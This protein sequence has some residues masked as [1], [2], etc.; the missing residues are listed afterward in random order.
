MRKKDLYGMSSFQVM[1]SIRRGVFYTFLTLFMLEVL[2]RTFTEAM[3]VMALPMLAN[4]ITQPTIW[5]PL[6]DKIGKR[7]IFIALGEGIAGVAYILI[8]PPV[9]EVLVGTSIYFAKMAY[10]YT[11]V[12]GLTILES[13]WSMSNVGW[14]ALIADLTLP[15]ERG[16]VMGKLN[17]IGAVGRIAGVFIGGIL[18]DYPVKGGG[19]SYLFF[20]SS[21]IMFSSALLVIFVVDERKITFSNVEYGTEANTTTDDALIDR[22][23][24]YSFLLALSVLLIGLANINRILN[25]YLRLALLASS[26]DMSII[27]NVSSITQLI[28]NPLVGKLSD[29]KGRKTILQIGFIVGT[30]LPLLYIL[31]NTILLLIPVSIL[32]GFVRAIIMTVSYAY[33]AEVIPESLRGRYFGQYNMMRTLSFGVFPILTAGIFTDLLTSIFISAGL[34]S[35]EAQ[36][37]SMI[38]VFYESSVLGLIGLLLFQV[39]KSIKK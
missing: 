13:I 17:S 33:V 11:L 16:N 27:S 7:K 28:A 22:R 30:L 14:S 25:Y 10:A 15:A 26:I 2:Q 38:F 35:V 34:N 12:F 21:L 1:L 18:Y 39:H 19:F 6:S 31:P 36:V 5:G 32:S 3:L 9:W 20:L 8:S 29:V 24:F 37:T 4:A 23:V